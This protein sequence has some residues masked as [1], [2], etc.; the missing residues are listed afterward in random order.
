VAA[1]P[2]NDDFA[3]AAAL[4]G[5]PANATGT[6]VNATTESGEP[7][8]TDPAWLGSVTPA[9]HSVWWSWTAPSDGDVT[10]D[11]CGSSF[12][13][14]LAVYTGN[15]IHALTPVKYNDTAFDG[16]GGID[17]SGDSELS[18]T[19]QS[20][21]VYRIAVD[22]VIPYWCAWTPCSPAEG[23]TGSIALALHK[24]PQ[25]A[26]DDFVNA[27][28]LTENESEQA[29]AQQ[30]N[31][32]ASKETG[33]PNHAGNAGGH[34]V[35]WNWTAPRTGVVGFNT[36]GSPDV[37]TLLAVYTGDGIGALSE[38]A[39]NDDLPAEIQCGKASGVRF[40]AS[41]GQTYHI[42]VDGAGGAI[43]GFR[44]HKT[45][46]PPNDEFENAISLSGL[47]DKD[48][49]FNSGA[50]SEPGEPNHAGKASGQSLWWR[51]TAPAD[52]SVQVDTCDSFPF[53]TDIDT[54]LAV[55][56]GDAV[57]ALSAVA[58]NDDFASC[59]PRSGLAFTASAGTTYHIAVDGAAGPNSIGVFVVSLRE[60]AASGGPPPAATPTTS[61]KRQKCKKKKHKH[62]AESAKKKTCKKKKRS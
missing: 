34:S 11:T 23:Q 52:G 46:G 55:Y 57:S 33:E 59:A 56:T 38:V 39:S 29:F 54:V 36:C 58:S 40:R 61:V 51:W 1:A 6:N 44:L 16:C 2:S 20:G 17:A 27:A 26:N 43:G 19:A 21:Q 3:N 7:E 32:G 4:S 12:D 30:T 25:P 41:A 53:P 9:G 60:T 5:L 24:S 62:S 8:H 48:A 13:T 15:N 10:L 42:A 49:G 28:V 18:F 14:L 45:P 31:A 35:W 22:G 47:S 50:T 37:D